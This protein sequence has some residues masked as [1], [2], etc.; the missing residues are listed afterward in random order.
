MKGLDTNVLV[1][2]LTQDDPVQS[3][4]ANAVIAETVARGERCAINAIVVCELIWVLREAYGFDKRTVATALERILDT[5][6]LSSRSKT[7]TWSAEPWA[8]IA[9]VPET[10]RTICSAGATGRPDARIR[11]P[12][13]ER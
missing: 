2:Y 7:R 9:A 10:S 6:Q 11:P 5:T 4:R 1:R 13:T 12:S 8:T 3:R